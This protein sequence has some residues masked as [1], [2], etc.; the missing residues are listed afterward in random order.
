MNRET[1]RMLQRQ[2]QLDRNGD[3]SVSS[4]GAQSQVQSRLKARP[5]GSKRSGIRE[6]FAS[7]RSELKKVRWPSRQEVI[8]YSTLVFV[9]LVLI[10][11]FI[12]GLNY[13]F[14]KLVF[15]LFK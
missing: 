6:Y 14:S 3:P 5:E 9:V 4:K 7:I 15:F 13:V 12:F 1:K 8:S 10:V 2:G 11:A